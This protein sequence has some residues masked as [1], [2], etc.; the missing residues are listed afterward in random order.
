[1]HKINNLIK[2]VIRQNKLIIINLHM[3]IKYYNAHI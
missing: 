2:K 1:M 3:K